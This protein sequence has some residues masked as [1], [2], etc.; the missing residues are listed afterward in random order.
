MQALISALLLLPTIPVSF[1][2][3]FLIGYMPYD[4]PRLLWNLCFLGLEALL[5]LYLVVMVA[6]WARQGRRGAAIGIAVATMVFELVILGVQLIFIR[7][8]NEGVTWWAVEAAGVLAMVGYVTA[9]GV[10]RRRNAI[11]TIG[12]IGALICGALMQWAFWDVHGEIFQSFF[13]WVLSWAL[14]VGVFVLSCL[15]CWG[16]D[17]LGGRSQ[18][19][20][21]PDIPGR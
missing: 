20:T 5:P 8:S 2:V 3:K 9:W 11:W 18:R 13:G 7:S 14:Y 1:G 16:F 10:A 12:L 21:T 6:L 17:A 4:W 19:A 15:I